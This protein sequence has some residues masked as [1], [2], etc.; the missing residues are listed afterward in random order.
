MVAHFHRR[1]EVAD[2]GCVNA[3]PVTGVRHDLGLVQGH[4]VTDPVAETAR[5]DVG[6]PAE[7]GYGL[8][9]GPAAPLLERLREVPV[10]ERDER[11]DAF[12]EQLV[13]EPVVEGEPR[14]V[15]R[16]A[17]VRYHPR[18]ADREAIAV[19]PEIAL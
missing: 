1:F 6:V 3:N 5:D 8:R 17:P 7:R 4:P 12:A 10:V 14:L 2:P 19:A 13:D 18:P 9:R 16:T 15:H 11:T